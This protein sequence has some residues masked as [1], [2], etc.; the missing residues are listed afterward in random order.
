MVQ[1]FVGAQK[2]DAA[3]NKTLGR[4]MRETAIAMLAIVRSEDAG[5]IDMSGMS[6]TTQDWFQRTTKLI[7]AEHEKGSKS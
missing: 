3:F 7:D 4:R 1:S 6:Q 5:T 2:L